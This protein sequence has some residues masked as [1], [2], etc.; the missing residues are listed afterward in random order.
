MNCKMPK[1]VMI[2]KSPYRI[3]E[4]WFADVNIAQLDKD[5]NTIIRQLDKNEYKIKGH[6]VIVDEKYLPCMLKYTKK[7]NKLKLD[8]KSTFPT[9]AVYVN[10]VFEHATGTKVCQTY[11]FTQEN[12]NKLISICPLESMTSNIFLKFVEENNIKEFSMYTL[13]K[14]PDELIEKSNLRCH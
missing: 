12:Y 7:H 4:G 2:E 5:T 13:S 8:K 14:I 1:I 10:A 9:P 11:E 3:K 6:V